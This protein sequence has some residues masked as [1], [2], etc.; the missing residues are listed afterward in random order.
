MLANPAASGGSVKYSL[1][2][3]SYTIKPGESQTLNLDRNW[4]I[5]FDNGLG[6]RVNYRLNDGEYRFTVSPQRGWDVEK[7]E[8]APPA[9]PAAPAAAAAPAADANAIPKL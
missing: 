1:N 3:F 2:E 6:R 8:D 9:A 7:V 5:A 4:T